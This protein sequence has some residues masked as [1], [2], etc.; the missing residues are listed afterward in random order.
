MF[1]RSNPHTTTR[2]SRMPSR[3]T[4]SSPTLGDAARIERIHLVLL[5][6]DQ[7]RDDDGRA[8]DEQRGNLVDRRLAKAGGHDRERVMSLEHELDDLL[9]PVAQRFEAEALARQISDFGK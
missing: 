9:L 5:Q 3:W 4:M 6:R 1:G 7:R 8:I 2:A